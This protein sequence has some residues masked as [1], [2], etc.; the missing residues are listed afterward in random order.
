MSALNEF[1][2]SFGNIANEKDDLLAIGAPYDDLLL[3]ETEAVPFEPTRKEATPKFED[4]DFETPSAEEAGSSLAAGADFDFSSLLNVPLDDVT[5]HPIDDIPAVEAEQAPAAEASVPEEDVSWDEGGEASLGDGLADD[6]SNPDELPSSISD[7]IEASPLDES[8]NL[9]ELPDLGTGDEAADRLDLGEG[10]P[11]LPDLG[12]GDEAAGGLDLGE[13]LPDTPGMADFGMAGE[14]TFGETSD[15]SAESSGELPDFDMPL[16]DEGT[17]LGGLDDLGGDMGPDADK[18]EFS[19][20]GLDNLFDK[21]KKE[22]APEPKRKRRRWKREKPVEA[23]EEPESDEIRLSDEDLKNFEKTLASYPL[24]LRIACEELIAEQVLVPQQLSKLVRYL[25]RGAPAKETAAFAGEIAGKTIVIP[26]SFQKSTGEALEAEQASFAYIFV[27]NFLPVLRLFSIIA[28]LAASL[29][30]LGYKFIYTPLDA[31][32]LYKR[33]YERIPA[34][35]YQR[36]NELFNK[37]FS[38]HRKKKWFYLY[39]EKFRDERRYML[40]EEK[41]DELLRNYPRDKKG[42]LDY[43]SLETNYMMNYDKANRILQR[44]LLDY[45]PDDLEG[46]IASGDNFIAWADSDPSRYGGKYEDA[47]F[48]YSRVMEKYGWMPPVVERMMKYFIRTDNL[49]EVLSLRYWFESGRKRELSLPALSELGGYLLDKQLEEV[50]GVSNPYVENIQGV[51]DLLLRAVRADLYLPEPHYHLA[52]YYKSLNNVYEERLTLENAIRAFDL[53]KEESVRRRLYRVD[54]HFRYANLLI[55]NKEFFPAEEN[56]IRGISLYEDFMSRRLISPS[57]RL[58]Q[59]YALKGDLEYFVKTGDMQAALND[60]KLAERYGWSPPETKYRMGAAFYQLED[61][62]NALDYFF[63]ASSDLPFNRRLLFA[64]G[65]AAYKRGDY[66]AAQGYY[67]RLLDLLE[68]QRL[69]LPILL[70]NDGPEFLEVGER[71]MMARN[72]I[73]VTYEAL[74]DI[75][76][77]REYRALALGYYAESARAWDT[78]TRNPETMVR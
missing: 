28:A 68:N 54:A 72:N 22:I 53:A 14:E 56:L 49:K 64:L 60:Y 37:A 4:M 42:I 15:E 75:T 3:P 1:K 43:A 32:S 51:R 24:N 23:E 59:L 16:G 39:A 58:G 21:G 70:P 26:K 12:T 11:E 35:E 25:V 48:A 76:G 31:E 18:D 66:Y 65:N 46:L 20:A 33:G 77:Y 34:G 45:A 41:Y 9:P 67:N 5:P 19:L 17:D 2:A 13:G 29:I 74:A 71:L 38:L 47:R 30:Y 44:D 10:L 6:F 40:A 52:R 7:E 36:A 27:H 50:K 8:E 61:W 63:Q 55:N 57:P 62:K 73:G 78:I 69:R